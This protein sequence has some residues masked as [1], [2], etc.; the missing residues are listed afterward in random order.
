M[1]GMQRG[2]VRIGLLGRCDVGEHGLRRHQRRLLIHELRDVGRIDAAA[3]GKARV[4][5]D[6]ERH[7]DLGV[8][9]GFRT[10]RAGGSRRDVEGG[11]GQAPIFGAADLGHDCLALVGQAARRYPER[12]A[13]DL[14]VVRGERCG[15]LLVGFLGE[16]WK[17]GADA[18]NDR[19]GR[20]HD[21]RRRGSGRRTGRRVG[22]GS[23]CVGCCG[24][25]CR[26]GGCRRRNRSRH[27]GRRHGCGSR[28]GGSR[29]SGGCRGDRGSRSSRC[30]GRRCG[31]RRGSRC[32][33]GD[34]CRWRFSRRRGRCSRCRRGWGR[35]GRFRRRRRGGDRCRWRYS[36]R[37][38]RCSRSRRRG[39]YG[40]GCLRG[41]SC[42][43]CG[44]RCRRLGRRDTRGSYRR[45]CRQ[46]WIGHLRQRRGSPRSVGRT[47]R[48]G[49]G[50]GLGAGH[51]RARDAKRRDRR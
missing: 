20:R 9:G 15:F 37:R 47:G 45:R 17:F 3:A 35:N 51:E 5:E 13:G 30:S 43:R 44:R 11:N 19:I 16:R 46:A 38:G 10:E 34:R 21:R 22:K 28:S 18:G 42:C 49:G 8:G 39:C 7:L 14:A 29:A 12:G 25:R 48:R 27:G 33:G 31:R 50:R 2:E 4:L 23:S 40:S 26:S 6:G 36:R 32:R 24:G 41:R 1:L